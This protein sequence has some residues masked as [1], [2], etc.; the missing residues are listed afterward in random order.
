[1][2]FS[3]PALSDVKAGHVPCCFYLLLSISRKLKQIE[4]KSVLLIQRYCVAQN[5]RIKKKNQEYTH[6]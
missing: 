4:R 6:G 5:S 1:M 2:Y 3:G